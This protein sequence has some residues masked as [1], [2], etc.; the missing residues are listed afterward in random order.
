MNAL[1]K[2]TLLERAQQVLLYRAALLK[3]CFTDSELQAVY[4]YR[5]GISHREVAKTLG[6]AR[7]CINAYTRKIKGISSLIA[8]RKLTLQQSVSVLIQCG[9]VS[10]AYTKR[11][12]QLCK[13]A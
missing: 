2:D 6:K 9:L 7:S 10:D 8:N 12:E 13:I 3:S 4:L 5:L 1:V 11:K